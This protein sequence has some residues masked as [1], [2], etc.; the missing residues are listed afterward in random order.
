MAAV[1][2]GSGSRYTLGMAALTARFQEG[3]FIL[4]PPEVGEDLPPLTLV[5]EDAGDDLDDEERA[6]LGVLIEESF[7]A[8]ECGDTRP[9]SALLA[10]LQARA[11]R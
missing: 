10:E 3:R 7:Q 4:E 11:I 1:A 2:R 5:L 9:A 6:A 8:S